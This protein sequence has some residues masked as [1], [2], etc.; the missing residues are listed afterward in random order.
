MRFMLPAPSN[1]SRTLPTGNVS[2]LTPTYHKI[3]AKRYVSNP[4]F[5]FL[6]SKGTAIAGS[7]FRGSSRYHPSCETGR[8]QSEGLTR[9]KR[10]NKLPRM[11]RVLLTLRLMILNRISHSQTPKYTSRSLVS[12]YR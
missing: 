12:R 7:G 6:R 11:K 3:P 4:G 2:P 5:Q 1:Y 9:K 8:D 10:K